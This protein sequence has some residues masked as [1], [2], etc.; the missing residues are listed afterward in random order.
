MAVRQWRIGLA[1]FF[2]TLRSQV[3]DH[4]EGDGVL[5]IQADQYA[6]AITSSA[7]AA[8]EG[9]AAQPQTQSIADAGRTAMTDGIHVGSYL[10]AGFVLL[11]LFAT[12]LIP[13]SAASEDELSRAA[14]PA[15]V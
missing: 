2:T 10:A 9:F 11:G 7:G 1:E 5:A 6:Y 8:I 15:H 12:A 4:L 3:A 14:P 13:K